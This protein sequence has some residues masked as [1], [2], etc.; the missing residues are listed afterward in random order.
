MLLPAFRTHLAWSERADEASA[1]LRPIVRDHLAESVR[2]LR[3]FADQH[4]ILADS[5]DYHVKIGNLLERWEV[6]RADAFADRLVRLEPSAPDAL[7]VVASA[8]RRTIAELERELERMMLPT[9]AELERTI[10]RQGRQVDE[11]RKKRRER[12]SDERVATLTEQ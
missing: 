4:T 6:E 10:V 3:A 9:N 12:E 5:P 2:Q 11:M 7:H 1:L 8:P